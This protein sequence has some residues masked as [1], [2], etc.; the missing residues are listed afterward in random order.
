MFDRCYTN[1]T[2]KIKALSQQMFPINAH[3]PVHLVDLRQKTQQVKF[4]EVKLHNL[5]V[6]K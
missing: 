4:R 1:Q 6:R 2:K 5:D 3:L